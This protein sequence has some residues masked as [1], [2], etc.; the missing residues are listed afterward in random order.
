MTQPPRIEA[1]TSRLFSVQYSASPIAAP[2]FQ[3]D[4]G[5][6]TV[7]VHSTVATSAGIAYQFQ[8]AYTLPSSQGIYAYRWTASF[9]AAQGSLA[10]ITAGLVQVIRT[11]PWTT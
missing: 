7:A 8:T 2:Q 9:S 6:S 10:D 11:R 3:V 1:G 4:I 5:S